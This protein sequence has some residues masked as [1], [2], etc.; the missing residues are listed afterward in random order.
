V[1][2]AAATALLLA[3]CVQTTTGA[4]PD[5]PDD[6]GAARQYYQLGARY[7]RNGKYELARD[8][9]KR[10]LDLNPRMAVAHS[11]L[12]LTY[13]ALENA[14][15]A[16]DHYAK[17]VRYAPD[18]PGV[19]NTYA[20]FLCRQERYEEAREQFEI[21]AGIPEN[22]DAEITLTNAGVCM[23]QKPDYELA[24]RFLREALE[25]KSS[26]GEALIQMAALKY[27]TEDF[28]TSRA[29]LQ[30]YLA[31]HRAMPEVLYLAVQVEKAL[32]DEEA[33]TEYANQLLR[34]FPDSAQ[35]RR[36]L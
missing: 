4:V 2:I 17:A 36:V 35:A 20:V 18:D 7:Y 26:Y 33:S 13:E 3:G 11:T 19:R 21:A 24:E 15:L 9:L 30:R 34:E 14:R 31:T 25:H 1:A 28:L 12:A 32:G 16:R 6:D 27:K 23:A 5:E 8:R 22:D 29:F 10:A